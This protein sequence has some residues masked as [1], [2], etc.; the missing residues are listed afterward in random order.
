MEPEDSRAEKLNDDKNKNFQQM[1][2]SKKFQ[3]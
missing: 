1:E 2:T 3:S